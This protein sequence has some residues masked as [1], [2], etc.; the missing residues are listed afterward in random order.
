[1]DHDRRFVL[2]EVIESSLYDDVITFTNTKS[3]SLSFLIDAAQKGLRDVSRLVVEC[4]THD[5]LFVDCQLN[6]SCWL[7]LLLT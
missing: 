2:G 1:M 6:E 3:H 5:S 4:A 7:S